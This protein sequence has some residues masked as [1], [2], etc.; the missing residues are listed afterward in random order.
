MTEKLRKN[1]PVHPVVDRTPR[2]EDAPA[3]RSPVTN[4]LYAALNGAPARWSA[5]L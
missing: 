5:D 1:R 4:A 3:R 2:P